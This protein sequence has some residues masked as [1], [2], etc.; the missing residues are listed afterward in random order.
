L[1]FLGSLKDNLNAEVALGTVTNVREACAWLGY[2][3]LFIR[4]K[5]NPLVYGITWEE[6]TFSSIVHTL[7]VKQHNMH[8]LERHI[9]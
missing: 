7:N 3:Y 5:T 2:T 4:M 8:F 9:F 1:Q 6:V